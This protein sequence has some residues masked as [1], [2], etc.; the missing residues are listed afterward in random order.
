MFFANEFQK[1]TKTD[2]CEKLNLKFSSC[3]K[4]IYLVFNGDI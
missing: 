3:I 1:P 2:I 4:C